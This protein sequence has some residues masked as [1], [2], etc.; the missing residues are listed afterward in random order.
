MTIELQVPVS[1]G[2]LIDKLTILAIKSRRISDPVRL[3]NVHREYDAL[4]AVARASGLRERYALCDLEEMLQQAN[5]SLWD[6]EDAIRDCERRADFG[7]A[8]IELARSVYRTND[9]RADIKNQ[10]NVR[11]GSLYVEEK[12]YAEY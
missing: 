11:C 10:I 3:A 9:R 4:D 2:E 5:E 12:S 6:I 7:P 8:F 1:V